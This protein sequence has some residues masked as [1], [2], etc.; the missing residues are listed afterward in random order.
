MRNLQEGLPESSPI[1]RREEERHEDVRRVDDAG[2]LEGNMAREEARISTAEISEGGVGGEANEPA[3]GHREP[4]VTP[5]V[6]VGQQPAG[7]RA[8]SHRSHRVR[9]GG[10]L[11]LAVTA[12]GGGRGLRM[13]EDAD[14]KAGDDSKDEE[15]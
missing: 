7:E 13:A 9:F 15:E 4:I 12:G 11:L 8:R 2:F 6:L 14:C 5:G 10:G 3:A 1:P